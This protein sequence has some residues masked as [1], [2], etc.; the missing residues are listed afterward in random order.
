VSNE[1][2]A[3]LYEHYV[4]SQQARPPADLSGLA[5]RAPYLERLIRRHFP[6]DRDAA[7]LDLGCGYGG[8]L[9]V[10]RAAGYTQLRGIDISTEQVEAARRLGI[11]GVTQGDL[12][13]SL[14]AIAPA[15]LDV[16]CAFDVLEHF[17]KDEMLPLVD[18][19][20]RVLRP[21]GRWIVHVPN[22]E[23][24]F[25]GAIR[26]G[27]LTHEVAFTRRS[28]AQLLLASGFRDVHCHED[29]P[30]PH[31]LTSSL[32]WL[33]WK[34]L[35]STLRFYVAVETGESGRGAVLTQNLLA[36]AIK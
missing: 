15:S 25:F 35:R 2:R 14:E 11:E 1:V 6:S 22:G 20:H 10:A 3:R 16:V 27:D 18:S 4:S 26:Y 13:P 29:E 30:V 28:I 36:I 33:L 32:R 17:G 7:V 5:A 34:L 19:V 23:S 9:H 24:P 8:L 12:L 31:G 21:G